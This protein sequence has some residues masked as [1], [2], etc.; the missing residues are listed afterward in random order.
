PEFDPAVIE[1]TADFLADLADD[2]PALEFA[3]G[4]GRI[5]LPLS[6]RGVRVH[7]IDL[8][9]AM[10]AQLRRKPGGDAIGVTVG[11]FATTK[12]D[13][14]FQLAYLVFNTIGNLTTQD[15]QVACFENAAAHLV[16]GGV[17]VIEVLVPR[18]QRLPPGERFQ[19]FVVT[20]EHLGF[21]EF[22]TANQRLI[23]HHY[24]VGKGDV[25]VHSMPFRYAWPAELDLMARIA[26]M[27]LRERW[28]DWNRAPFTS[29]SPKHISVWQKPST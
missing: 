15:D 24:F 12:V 10:V 13:D 19:P 17:F 27:R 6:R 8:S 5:A 29:D 18:L 2:G 23:S 20:P 11:D 21:D 25:A 22:D 4:T 28:S 16:A 1:Q 3:I 7:G 14:N 9:E 26:G